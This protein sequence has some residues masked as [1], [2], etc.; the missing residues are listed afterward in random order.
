[1]R[2]PMVGRRT[3]RRQPGT[4]TPRSGP[5]PEPQPVPQGRP[6]VPP[7]RLAL[8]PAALA[9]WV[10]DIA[11]RV[12]CPPDFVAVGVMAAAAAVIGRQIAIR[13]KRQDDWAVVPNLWGLGVGLP[14][15]M[16]SP[17]LAE[18]LRPLRRLITDAQ[19]RDEEHRLAQRMWLA[20]QKA[21]RH[22]LARRLREAVAEQ[23]PP[24]ALQEPVEPARRDPPP[25]ERRYLVNDTTVE[26]LGEPLNQNPNGLLLFRDELS[27]FLH[28][29]EAERCRCVTVATADR[30]RRSVALSTA[31]TGAAKWQR[32]KR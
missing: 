21:R 14:G 5:W 3:G 32:T 4:A 2:R 22:D 8:L 18:A 15:S 9:P 17:A 29:M 26:K 30:R 23:E 20:E 6:P 25:V 7:F 16:K 11:D 31:C 28:T 13:P 10:A 1:M 27:G 24:E 19:A 12:Q